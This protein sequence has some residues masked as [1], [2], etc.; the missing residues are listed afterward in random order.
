MGK[1]VTFVIV[2]T[3][4]MGKVIASVLHFERKEGSI[5]SLIEI[6]TFNPWPN[7][8]KY[9]SSNQN[10]S[11]NPKWMLTLPKDDRHFDINGRRGD[12]IISINKHLHY[13]KKCNRTRTTGYGKIIKRTSRTK[14]HNALFNICESDFQSKHIGCRTGNGKFAEWA[15]LHYSISCATRYF[16]IS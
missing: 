12:G 8:S 6:F 3:Y 9:L 4:F 13:A 15:A 5:H 2:F 1:K 7:P 11:F 14:I 10:W 16:I